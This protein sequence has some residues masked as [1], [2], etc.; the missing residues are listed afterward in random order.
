LVNLIASCTTTLAYV[1]K[2][3]I[4]VAPIQDHPD[5]LSLD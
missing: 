1:E 2:I 4:R 3:S 5:C